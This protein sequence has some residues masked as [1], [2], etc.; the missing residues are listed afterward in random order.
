MGH[1][2]AMGAAF[3]ESAIAELHRIKER[4]DKAMAQLRDDAQLFWAPDGE[5]NSIDV[6]VRHLSGNM[7]SRWTEF[8]T[9]DGAKPER[10][11][12][13][14]FEPAAQMTREKLL[15]E[16]EKGWRC[17]FDALSVL[18]PA[19]LARTVTVSGKP[20]SVMQAIF[21]QSAHYATHVGQ[22]VYVAKH[23]AG[24]SWQTL[25]IPRRRSR[26]P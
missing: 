17:L 21:Q 9:T 22:I 3:L 6:L 12:D 10:N 19:D 7:L 8:L 15:G 4:A 5:S 16:W 2:E 20:L 1:D 11:R 13:A 25:S 24:E 23:L 14:E 26:Q 18:T